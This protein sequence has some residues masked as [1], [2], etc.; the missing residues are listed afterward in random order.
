MLA[1]P[2]FRLPFNPPL[3]FQPF[4]LVYLEGLTFKQRKSFSG[5]SLAEIL[6]FSEVCR[7]KRQKGVH[8]WQ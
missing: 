5:Y 4:C 6:L 3:I 1:I 2:T 8:Q 7:E